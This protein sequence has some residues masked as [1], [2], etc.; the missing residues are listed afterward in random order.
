[1]KIAVIYNDSKSQNDIQKQLPL[2]GVD[3]YFIPEDSVKEIR[4][5]WMKKMLPNIIGEYDKVLL[6]GNKL[7]NVV[8][9]EVARKEGKS[10]RL[11]YSNMDVY[12]GTLVREEATILVPTYLEVN[13]V[14]R[15]YRDNDIKRLLTS[16]IP[17]LPEISKDNKIQDVDK[18]VYIDIETS[19]LNWRTDNIDSIQVISDKDVNPI[20][21]DDNVIEYATYLF[22]YIRGN[23]LTVVGHNLMFDISFLTHITGKPW[24]DLQIHDTMLM[25]K[26]RGNNH[27][28]LK[29][30]SSWYNTKYHPLSYKEENAYNKEYAIADIL[31][32]REIHQRRVNTGKG[33]R[34]IDILTHESL[35]T[36]IY[37]RMSGVF[38]NRDALNN[39]Y[40]ELKGRI[41]TLE[42]TLNSYADIEWTNNNQIAQA[43]LDLG[44]KL[45]DKT[46]TGKYSV[47]AAAL[48]KVKDN[49]VVAALQEYKK[50]IKLTSTFYS[51]YDTSTKEEPYIYPTINALGTNTGRTSCVSPNLQQVPSS[52][53]K[54]FTSR[55]ISGK[56]AQFDFAQSELR[57]AALITGDTDFANALKVDAH[58]SIMAKALNVPIEDIDK[59]TRKLGKAFNF[60]MLYGATSVKA[61]AYRTGA[62]ENMVEHLFNTFSKSYP[63]LKYWQDR[64]KAIAFEH[65]RGV[66]TLGFIRDYRLTIEY[67]Y[68]GKEQKECVNSPIQGLSAYLCQFIMNYLR[69]QLRDYHSIPVMQIHDSVFVD[70]HPDEI[71]L[72]QQLCL[73]AF[74]ELHN[75]PWFNSLAG[76]GLVEVE[77][78]LT[79]N[80]S[81]YDEATEYVLLSTDASVNGNV[82]K[83]D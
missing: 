68:K 41:E 48:E 51:E 23:E 64:Q 76:Y 32:T 4:G 1:M 8:I 3:T 53:K 74:Q 45:K 19:G 17:N 47:S 30:L 73:D 38:V 71:E 54:V 16:T 70:T 58:S 56:I 29:H 46:S 31:A 11:V 69:K 61:M 9:P 63:V 67:G 28:S 43:L 44:V 65:K 81:F 2:R 79:F 5:V 72:V 50:L 39:V 15:T 42:T 78:E 59:E 33:L 10:N 13:A 20:Y 27:N 82:C 57:C 26:A 75:V 83:V 21:V 18:Y 25:H 37:A 55:F 24:Y 7:S 6:V 22:E 34:Y 35:Q 77:G 52:V 49:E 40:Q 14:T 80:D 66:D 60:G 62:D 36:F 12:H